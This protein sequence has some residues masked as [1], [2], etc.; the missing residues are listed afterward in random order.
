MN[1]DME[2]LLRAASYLQT[3]T[4]SLAVTGIEARNSEQILKTAQ[5]YKRRPSPMPVIWRLKSTDLTEATRTAAAENVAPPS[6]SQI[7]SSQKDD[8]ITETLVRTAAMFTG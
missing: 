2:E 8:S 4:A 7:A 6:K 1:S 3:N 5:L